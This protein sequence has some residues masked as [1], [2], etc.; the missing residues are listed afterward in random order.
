[1]YTQKKWYQCDIS[2]TNVLDTR[3]RHRSIR[4]TSILTSFINTIF[5]SGIMP[6]DNLIM[7]T[8][9]HAYG[10]AI[11]RRR[12][13]WESIEPFNRTNRDRATFMIN[14]V[15][16]GDTHIQTVI[17]DARLRINTWSIIPFAKLIEG[18]RL[19]NYDGPSNVIL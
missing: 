18:I 19:A 16:T 4:S 2:K 5:P 10:G 6:I 13:A 7:T 1:M 14:S 15:M 11:V 3:E 12:F 9:Q 8:R 17:E